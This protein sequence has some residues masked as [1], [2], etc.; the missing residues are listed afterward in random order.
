MNADDILLISDT[1]PAAEVVNYLNTTDLIISPRS[2]PL[3]VGAKTFIADSFNKNALVYSTVGI[4][5]PYHI[6]SEKARAAKPSN[7]SIKISAASQQLPLREALWQMRTNDTLW[8]LDIDKKV[9]IAS[10]RFISKEPG[11]ASVEVTFDDR[12]PLIMESPRTDFPIKMDDTKPYGES[13]WHVRQND[14]FV[15]LNYPWLI[16]SK[17]F[18]TESLED[19]SPVYPSMYLTWSGAGP[20]NIN[21][22]D[23]IPKAL[24]TNIQSSET[25][26]LKE[27]L[28]HLQQSDL[29][30]II[31]ANKIMRVTGKRFVWEGKEPDDTLMTEITLEVLPPSTIIFPPA[32]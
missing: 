27:S 13:I 30:H 8:I 5:W 12:P 6:D 7:E 3:L 31:D 15:Q 11:I 17:L 1:K 16:L 32:K 20:E 24:E 10:K 21:G 4:V 19:D 26:L 23:T 14:L 9:R 2:G 18:H 22:V 28:W 25:R 29:L